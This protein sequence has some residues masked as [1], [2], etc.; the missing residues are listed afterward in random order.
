MFFELYEKEKAIIEKKIRYKF[1]HFETSKKIPLVKIMNKS[2]ME[3]D[4]E[5]YQKNNHWI[6]NVIL[7]ID[8]CS[9]NLTFT[10]ITKGFKIETKA[11]S[12]TV[13]LPKAKVTGKIQFYGNK[14][15][16]E[17]I[18]YHD[19]NWNYTL[20]SALTYGKGWY[21]GKIRSKSYNIVIYQ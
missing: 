1:K 19:H 4:V 18:G 17:G 11:E 3:F 5:A 2:I 9:A 21:W 8:D 14:M 13:A 7:N 10:G 12:W 20:L 15:N 6:Y 16:V